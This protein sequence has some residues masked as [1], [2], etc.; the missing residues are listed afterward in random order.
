[1]HN[2]LGYGLW[3]SSRPVL[4]RGESALWQRRKSWQRA[5]PRENQ[6]GWRRAFG[7]IR[8]D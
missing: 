1:M 2:G 8:R 6:Q 7:F 3:R 5:C 4:G